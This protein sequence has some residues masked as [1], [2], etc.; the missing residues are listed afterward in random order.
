M[1]K[2]EL[3]VIGAGVAGLTA[4]A[5]AARLGLHVLVVERMGVGG[6]VMNVER[7]DNMP[8]FPQG[9]SGFELGPELQDRAEAAGAEF[10]LD[11][12]LSLETLDDGRHQLRCENEDLQARAVIIAAGSKLKMLGVPGEENLQGRGVS[13]CA[14]CDGPLFRGL[15]V[16][17]VGGGDSAFGEA[18]VLAGCAG[19]VVM[20]Y[21]ESHPHAQAYLQVS[22]INNPNIEQ[23][24][25]AEVVAINDA[26][27]SVCGVTIQQGDG[28]TRQ[29]PVEGI[30]VYAGLDANAAFLGDVLP[31]DASGRIKTD[32]S[33]ATAV[34][35]VFAAGDIRAGSSWLLTAAAEDG[36]AAARSAVRYLRD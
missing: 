13:H 9:I 22:A 12:V 25:N 4:A 28:T 3:A 2:A 30:F 33:M 34:P 32:A 29:L 15:S 14:S 18:A 23:I 16:C 27:G 5:E 11:T 8:G 10:T 20:V 19:K 36:S 26:N 35:G 31:L 17:V 24:A 21:R 1:R 6:Q 7:I